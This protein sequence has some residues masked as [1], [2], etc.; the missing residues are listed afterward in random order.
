MRDCGAEAEGVVYADP[1]AALAIARRRGAGKLRHINV[2][3]FW[4]LEKQV[5]NQWQLRKVL[6]TENAADLMTKNLARQ[7]IHKY[8]LQ[9]NQHRVERRQ[10]LVDPRGIHRLFGP[11]GPH[12]LQ[13]MMYI[14][15]TR[16]HTKHDI[17]ADGIRHPRPA[18]KLVCGA[19]CSCRFLLQYTAT[20]APHRST[21]RPMTPRL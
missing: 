17:L 1:S 10:H 12:G 6:G 18:S 7:S 19:Y 20:S 9:I 11:T 16:A 14:Q 8:I 2:S 5:T 4:V 21:T 13:A 15:A 3:C